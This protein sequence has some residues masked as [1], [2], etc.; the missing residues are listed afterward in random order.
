MKKRVRFLLLA[1]LLATSCKLSDQNR[2]LDEYPRLGQNRI[3]GFDVSLNYDDFI[4]TYKDE[5]LDCE[6][7]HESPFTDGFYTS[8]YK[9]P[10]KVCHFRN[11]VM[12][13]F[14]DIV[15]PKYDIKVFRKN[16]TADFPFSKVL[17]D[18]GES[19]GKRFMISY[20]SDLNRNQDARI[21]GHQRFHKG[22]IYIFS[23]CVWEGIR[24]KDPDTAILGRI[25]YTNDTLE[26]KIQ[27]ILRTMKEKKEGL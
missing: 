22:V 8:K 26:N 19:T 13:E 23:K 14:T 20:P 6:D 16:Y 9:Y 24:N 10:I 17:N 25:H 12:V 3:A 2:P 27:D 1:C 11:G 21:Y 7:S 4:N 5:L 18:L 15:N